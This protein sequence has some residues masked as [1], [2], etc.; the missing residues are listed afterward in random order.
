L[1]D[2]LLF[3]KSLL[4]PCFDPDNELDTSKKRKDWMRQEAINSHYWDAGIS[5]ELIE[6]YGTVKS[7]DE[8][9]RK[10]EEVK[11][12]RLLEKAEENERKHG[13]KNIIIPSFIS[14]F[15]LCILLLQIPFLQKL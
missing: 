10:L 8:A 13:K 12:E 15:F 1:K 11:V 14:R 5:E 2:E 3:I 7:L 4:I 6:R 9:E